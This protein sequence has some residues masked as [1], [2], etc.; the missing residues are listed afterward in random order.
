MLID[1]NIVEEYRTFRE[2]MLREWRTSIREVV[3]PAFAERGISIDSASAINRNDEHI[4][5]LICTI[6]GFY[7]EIRASTKLGFNV[8]ITAGDNR[9][10]WPSLP[11]SALDR[12]NYT[13][14]YLLDWL[15]TQPWKV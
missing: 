11:M 9:I 13:V 5:L 8:S 12:K 14:Q 3:E 7:M 1:T 15:D 4:S 2:E 6:D 10:N